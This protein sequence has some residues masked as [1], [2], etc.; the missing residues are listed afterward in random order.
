MS[1]GIE[2]IKDNCN[3]LNLPRYISITNKK[4][5]SNRNKIKALAIQMLQQSQ[6]EMEAKV[7]KALNSGALD[8]DDWDENSNPAILPKCIVIAIM[9]DEADQYK[10]KGTSFEKEVKKEVANL[11]CFI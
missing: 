8:I 1:I 7:E 5:M 2:L 6:K 9:E 11:K 3:F 10:A 4:D